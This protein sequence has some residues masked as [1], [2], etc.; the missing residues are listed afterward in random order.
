MLKLSRLIEATLSDVEWAEFKWQVKSEI[1]QDKTTSHDNLGEKA[2]TYALNYLALHPLVSV[3]KKED[4]ATK[5]ADEI[6]EEL[7]NHTFD[8][9]PNAVIAAR[10]ER[11]KI[12]ERPEERYIKLC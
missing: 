12:G 4:I 3:L 2:K 6:E 1:Y 5:M 7:K 10:L 8:T 9:T 11:N